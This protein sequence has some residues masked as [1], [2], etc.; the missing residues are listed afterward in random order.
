MWHIKH[1]NNIRYDDVDGINFAQDAAKWLAVVKLVTFRSNDPLS[2][3][4]LL[5][6][7]CSFRSKCQ[8]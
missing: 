7:S 6:N 1:L 4:Q 8:E 3:Y 5:R 2:H